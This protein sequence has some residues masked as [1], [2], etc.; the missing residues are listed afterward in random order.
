MK[1]L[2]THAV[3]VCISLMSL[4]SFAQTNSKP[5]INEPDY[6]KP[7][8]F[9]NLPERIPVNINNISS[10]FNSAIGVEVGKGISENPSTFR[11]EGQVIANSLTNNDKQQNVVIRSTNYNGAGFTISK[12]IDA[13]GAVT[14]NGRLINLKYGDLY[15]LEKD[16]EGYTLV[17][18]NF[19]DLINE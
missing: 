3:C 5:P 10:L 19:Y 14:Y 18:K 12:T 16:K 8:L 4:S 9:D 17:K 15:L 1:N 11:I 7:R 2:R 6:N 13:D